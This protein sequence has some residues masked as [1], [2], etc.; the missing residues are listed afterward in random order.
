MSHRL[1]VA[2]SPIILS[3]LCALLASGCA[4]LGW[5]TQGD[6]EVPSAYRIGAKARQNAAEEPEGLSWSD[7]KFEKLGK[8]AKKLT[9]QG[10][11]RELAI[12]TYREADDLFRQGLRADGDQRGRLF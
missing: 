8:T 7:F 5:P 1:Q 3:A 11:N 12:T 9:G 2:T 10:T 6:S 4:S